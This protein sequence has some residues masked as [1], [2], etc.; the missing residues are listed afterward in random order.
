MDW[1]NAQVPVMSGRPT[2]QEFRLRGGD[3]DLALCFEEAW[4][5]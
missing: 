2:Y 1:L 4:A 3:S 5:T